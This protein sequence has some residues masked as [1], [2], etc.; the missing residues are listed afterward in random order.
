MNKKVE[1]NVFLHFLLVIKQMDDFTVS[2]AK[3]VLLHENT[4]FTDSVET[5]K[6]IY[7]QLIRHVTKGLLKRSEKLENGAKKVIYSKTELFFA[8]AFTPNSRR[9]KSPKFMG[10]NNQHII[11]KEIDHQEE[12]KKEFLAYEIDLRTVIEEAK[13]YKRLS[14]RFPNLQDQLEEHHLHAKEK[15]IRLLGKI[16]ALQNL[17]GYKETEHS[18][19]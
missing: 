16:N 17:L 1:M 2:E 13:E 12:L 18:L 14:A 8:A 5:R 6:F 9:K 3:D 11:N 15:S 10:H 19:C 4:E 7:R